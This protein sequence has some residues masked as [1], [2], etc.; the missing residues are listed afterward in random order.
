MLHIRWKLPGEGE[1]VM[2]CSQGPE[3]WDPI[4]EIRVYLLKTTS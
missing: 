2:V 1:K 3:G 4:E